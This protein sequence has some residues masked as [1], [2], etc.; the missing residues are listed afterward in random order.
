MVMPRV[1]CRLPS[2]SDSAPAST[3][4]R[5]DFPVPL[6]PTRAVRSLGVMSQSA[7]S[8]NTRGPNR[9]PAE[10]SWSI[11][12]AAPERCSHCRI[13]SPLLEHFAPF[14]I[15]PSNE[16]TGVIQNPSQQRTDGC[17]TSRLFFARCGIARILTGI[18]YV[19]PKARGR[20]QW[21]EKP[22]RCPEFPVRNLGQD[23]VCP[24]L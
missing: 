13:A 15:Y 1:R 17:P 18:A 23:C 16:P 6:A 2:S 22:A 21:Y 20:A 10:E 5:V 24:F 4:S 11:R 12:K 14:R 8:N 9:L 3:L 19:E 7:F